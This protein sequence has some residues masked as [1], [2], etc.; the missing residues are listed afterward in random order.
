MG[1]GQNGVLRVGFEPRLRL[2]FQ[3]AK[4]SSDAGL[5]VYRKLDEAMKL[6][7]TAAD[8]LFDFRIVAEPA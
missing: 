4:I 3:G 5:L 7:A 2:A 8:G 6:T 1:D